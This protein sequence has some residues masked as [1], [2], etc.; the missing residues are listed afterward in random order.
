MK[1]KTTKLS[2]FDNLELKEATFQNVA[3]PDHFHDTYSIGLIKEG[4][5]KVTVNNRTLL[6][7]AG[8]I[9]IINPFEV[10]SN[11]FYDNEK[12][13]YNS[14]YLNKDILK[15]CIKK[16]NINCKPTFH[17]KSLINDTELFQQLINFHSN[18]I[19]NTDYKLTEIITHLL[20]NYQ[21]ELVTNNKYYTTETITINEII[22]YFQNHFFDKIKIDTLSKKYKLNTSQLIRA[23][24]AHTG[25][26]PISYILLLKL[27]HSKKL[28][29]QNQSIVQVALDCGF[30][31]QSHFNHYFFK[32][33]GI[34]PI[35][36]RKNCVVI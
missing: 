9:V 18:P 16:Q 23:F 17:F 7:T 19:D 28:I 26:T 29:L 34:T 4:I 31:D 6:S 13:T 35:N 21:E 2:N 11:S 1:L 20:A 22:A 12:W 25:L 24:K 36:F 14:L 15:Y 30:Y 32:F 27:N 8:S 3:F 10:H 33:F 5:E